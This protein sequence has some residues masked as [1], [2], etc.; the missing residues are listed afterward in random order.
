MASIG[1]PA[2][3]L[4]AVLVVSTAALSWKGLV[5]IHV[6]FT[7]GGLILGYLIPKASQPLS[8]R[9]RGREDD[10][11]R[12]TFTR[13]EIPT[14]KTVPDIAASREAVKKDE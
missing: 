4:L 6:F 12:D 9:G 8:L 11:D 2:S 13:D 3:F 7:V 10:G 5:P 1:W 14:R